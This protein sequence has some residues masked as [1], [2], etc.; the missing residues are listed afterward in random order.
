MTTTAF[1]SEE[2]LFNEFNYF[3]KNGFFQN[4]LTPKLTLLRKVQFSESSLLSSINK[5]NLFEIQGKLLVQ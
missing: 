3:L 1:Q 4:C 2:R 5:L